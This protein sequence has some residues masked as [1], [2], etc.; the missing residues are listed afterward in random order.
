MHYLHMIGNMLKVLYVLP[1]FFRTTTLDDMHFEK[2]L[3]FNAS[4]AFLCNTLCQTFFLGHIYIKCNP[5]SI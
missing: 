1:Y 3:P 2:H 5:Y 4:Y